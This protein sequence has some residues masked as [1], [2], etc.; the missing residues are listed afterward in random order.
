MILRHATT[1]V[2]IVYNGGIFTDANAAVNKE[3]VKEELHPHLYGEKLFKPLKIQDKN[4]CVLI[5]VD[6]IQT[7]AL[8]APD[9]NTAWASDGNPKFAAIQGSIEN[10]GF[11][12]VHPP[13]ALYRDKSSVLLK[14]N[15]RSRFEI[16]VNKCGYKNIIADIYESD[17]SASKND[18]E[19]ALSKFGQA[20]NLQGY[21]PHGVVDNE[22]LVQNCLQA[23]KE[24]WIERDEK[25]ELKAH[26]KNSVEERIDD[27]CGGYKLTKI[28]KESLVARIVAQTDEFITGKRLSLI[29]I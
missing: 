22:D 28:P 27:I 25:G 20:S 14:I 19:N 12:L 24:G 21:D 16:L 17:D 8:G 29:H 11:R 4:R 6:R 26:G 18:I 9:I 2:P 7:S 1:T 15:G 10:F 5:N 23:I 3:Y 13:I